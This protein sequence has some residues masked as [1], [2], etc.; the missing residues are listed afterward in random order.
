MARSTRQDRCRGGVDDMSS[1]CENEY[2]LLMSEC[3]QL[4]AVKLLSATFT[5]PD[6]IILPPIQAM[7][8]VWSSEIHHDPKI[9]ITLEC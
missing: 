8:L 2:R 1:S 7:S 4:P 3:G 5:P 6:A 9:T